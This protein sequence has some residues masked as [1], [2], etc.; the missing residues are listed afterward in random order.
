MGRRLACLALAGCVLIAASPAA[1][2]R[3]GD[4]KRLWATVNVCNT[5]KHPDTVGIR[6]S[7][8]GTGV[9]GQA[10]YMRFAL[11]YRTSAGDWKALPG[12]GSSG[13]VAVGSARYVVRLAGRSFHF[14]PPAAGVTDTLRGIVG[15]QWRKGTRVVHRAT[16]TTT[17]GHPRAEGSDPRGYS[18]ASC[19]VK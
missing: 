10:M 19:E 6:A 3:L 17:A 13:W 7:M 18:A 2:V 11:Q 12:G 16:R 8:P 5:A 1:A 4:P 14:L 9:A 15:F